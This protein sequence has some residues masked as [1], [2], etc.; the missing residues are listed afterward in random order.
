MNRER[1]RERMRAKRKRKH[2][3][4]SEYLELTAGASS[5]LPIGQ[6]ERTDRPEREHETEGNGAGHAAR[7][8]EGWRHRM[9]FGCVDLRMMVLLWPRW[10]RS[11]P[12]R[13]PMYA[14]V[15]RI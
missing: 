11:F 5:A 7:A 6:I 2:V 15:R 1:E 8:S 12:G 14:V 9:I 13:V 10:G 4:R 3:P